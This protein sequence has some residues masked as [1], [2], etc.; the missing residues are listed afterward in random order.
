MSDRYG[1][2]WIRFVAYIIDTVVVNIGAGV[3]GALFGLVAGMAGGAGDPIDLVAGLMGL[4]LGWLY[5]A[6]LESSVHQATLG[7]MILGMTV[8]AE[9][10]GR[11]SFGRATGRY[12]AKL[13]SGL[14]LFIGFI[15]AGFDERKQGL[16]D[17]LASTLVVKAKPGELLNEAEAFY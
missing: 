7:K 17:K 6:L 2:F 8:V 5:F 16:H 1:G 11:I 12:F 9:D 15:M 10:G 14:I 3:I 13:L 4:I